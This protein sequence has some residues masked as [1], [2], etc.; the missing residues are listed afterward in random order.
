ML[1]YR[2]EH[3]RIQ[4]PT[5]LLFCGVI[6]VWWNPNRHVAGQL[7]PNQTDAARRITTTWLLETALEG[8]AVSQ[9]A[10]DVEISSA[11]RERM[12]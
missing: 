3:A 7:V 11:T 6:R 9:G 12:S 1:R 4:E 5:K 10:Q 2:T 8:F